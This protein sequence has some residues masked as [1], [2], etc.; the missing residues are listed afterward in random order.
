M[1]KIQKIECTVESLQHSGCVDWFLRQ[2]P[3][4]CMCA[5]VF[6]STQMVPNVAR[7]LVTITDSGGRV[8]AE[9]SEIYHSQSG[10]V[11]LPPCAW[12]CQSVKWE[13]NGLVRELSNLI[14]I[15]LLEQRMVFIKMLAN[16]NF[17]T[18]LFYMLYKILYTFSNIL[19]SAPWFLSFT[20]PVIPETPK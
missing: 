3:A 5:S 6:D 1:L 17:C 12:V 14:S 18:L 4:I 8:P 2:I 16:H 20:N 10:Q 11:I 19:I 15:K 7:W 13:D 9:K